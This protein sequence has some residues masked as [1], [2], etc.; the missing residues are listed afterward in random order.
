MEKRYYEWEDYTHQET[1]IRRNFTMKLPACLWGDG[2]KEMD[3]L[4]QILPDRD[5]IFTSG[6]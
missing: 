6:E 2:K 3:M 4:L 5:S 1:K